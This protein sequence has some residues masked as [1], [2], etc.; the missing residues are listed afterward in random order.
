LLRTAS[1]LAVSDFEAI[2]IRQLMG[3]IERQRD[4]QPLPVLRKESR[5][6]WG[7]RLIYFA[8][9]RA[10]RNARARCFT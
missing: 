8:F 3:R 7:G 10:S 4:R 6:R 9:A 1:W 5:D 2:D